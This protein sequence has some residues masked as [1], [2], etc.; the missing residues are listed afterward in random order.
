LTVRLV[1]K[2]VHAE[3]NKEQSQATRYPLA[4]D[5]GLLELLTTTL[6]EF[7]NSPQCMN[8]AHL[9]TCTFPPSRCPGLCETRCP[10]LRILHQERVQIS[11]SRWF[12]PKMVG[13]HRACCAFLPSSSHFF[14][15]F[16]LSTR[17]LGGR[18]LLLA[19]LR[20]RLLISW[21]T[22]GMVQSWLVKL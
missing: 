19:H 2:E 3:P 5:I 16:E 7:R 22:H 10:K 1:R 8:I 6:T 15:L 21:L 14:H 4:A 12:Q 9:G 11:A 17:V 20:R 13:V 18:L